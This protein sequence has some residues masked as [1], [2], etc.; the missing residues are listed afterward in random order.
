MGNFK[1]SMAELQEIDARARETGDVP[2][3]DHL[4]KFPE[5]ERAGQAL[6]LAAQLVEFSAYEIA[7]KHTAS[8]VAE[9]INC[10]AKIERSSS[11][12]LEI[13]SGPENLPL[14]RVQ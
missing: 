7:G 6:R 5:P 13:F 2:F 9:L 8:Y 10:A 1:G 12:V 4:E 3:A 14:R 11:E